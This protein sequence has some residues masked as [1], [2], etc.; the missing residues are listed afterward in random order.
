M[1]RVRSTHSG[2]A[3]GRCF[4]PYVVNNHAF[5][6]NTKPSWDLK[7]TRNHIPGPLEKTLDL[8]ERSFHVTRK[9]VVSRV[10]RVQ[11]RYAVRPRPIQSGYLVNFGFIFELSIERCKISTYF[12]T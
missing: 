6:E 2:L 11:R 3:H 10:I 7:T 8:R 5:L 1:S 9:A 12:P 4:D